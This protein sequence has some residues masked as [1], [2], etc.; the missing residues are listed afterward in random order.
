MAF[1]PIIDVPI[2]SVVFAF[3]VKWKDFLIR[4]VKKIH[5]PKILL[6][7]LVSIPLLIFEEHINCGAYGCTNVFIPPT[8][9]F[10]LVLEL[11]LFGLIKLSRIKNIIWQTI[12]LSFLGILFEFFLGVDHAELHQLALAQP[13][14]FILLT[15]WVGFSYTFAY[16][17]PLA[18]I[19][20]NNPLPKI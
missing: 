17:L 9:P 1:G 8:I 18:I 3:L 10:L 15:L 7:L 14:I 5:L 4:W 19:N 13:L 12:F 11:I 16:F 6:A 2:L 20:I